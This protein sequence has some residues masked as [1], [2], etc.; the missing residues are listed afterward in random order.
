[1]TQGGQGAIVAVGWT[2]GWRATISLRSLPPGATVETENLDTGE[3]SAV[4]AGALTLRLAERRSSTVLLY[5][6][7]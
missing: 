2:G 4:A 3:K 1:M 7:S 6:V 5:R